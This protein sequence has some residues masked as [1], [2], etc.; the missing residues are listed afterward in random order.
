ME[1]AIVAIV[2]VAVVGIVLGAVIGLA[3]KIFKVYKDPRVEKITEMLPGANCGGCGYAGCSDFAKAIVEKNEDPSKCPVCNS[4]SASAIAEIMGISLNSEAKKI[5]VVLCGGSNSKAKK[6]AAYNGI[7]D[8]K[9][10]VLVAG[11]DKACSYGCLGLGTCAKACP[12]NAIEI[13]DGLA[14]VHPEL[15]VGCGKCVDACPR[16]L[17]KLISE[18]VEVNIFCSSPEKGAK[19]MKACKAACI[20]CRKCMKA[21]D[22]GQIEAKGFLLEVN[23]ENPPMPDII[24]KAKCPTKCLGEKIPPSVSDTENKE[25]A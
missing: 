13:R 9:S 12:F 1:T 20:G 17:I 23:Y 6:D 8:C 4:D 19:K 15:C 11:G 7:K 10:A 24:E 22:N 14:V 2:F 21:A 25:L 3:A 18:S 5:A 16:K